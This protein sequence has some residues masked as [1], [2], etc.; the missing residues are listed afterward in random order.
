[1][2]KSALLFIILALLFVF[3]ACI[4][5]GLS[6]W[7]YDLPNGYQIVHISAR[8]II[9]KDNNPVGGNAFVVEAYV[10]EFCYN[11]RYIGLKRVDVPED[12]QAEI[13]RS[14]PVYYLVN[15]TTKEI[16]GELSGS[17]YISKIEELNIENMCDWILTNPA[18][19]GAY[20]PA[21]LT[22]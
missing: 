10:S 9:C 2:K 17:E 1:M 4:G 18:P 3:S 6:D 13:D 22:D 5:P 20:C 11:D 21:D 14:N 7:H 16:Y 12:I 8:N 15:M 19:E